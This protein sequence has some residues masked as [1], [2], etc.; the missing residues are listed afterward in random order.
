MPSKAASMPLR[1][2]FTNAERLMRELIEHLEQGYLPK[3]QELRRVARKDEASGVTNKSVRQQCHLL[4]SSD[5]FTRRLA[6]DLQEYIDS[7]ADEMKPM[8]FG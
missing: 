6:D 2:K 1:D 7:I 5:D 4:I 8:I 3:L